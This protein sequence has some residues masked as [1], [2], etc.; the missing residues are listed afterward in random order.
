V[1]IDLL[2]GWDADLVVNGVSV[3]DA[4]LER[5]V[6]LGQV[7]FDP[8]P[9]RAIESLQAGRNCMTATYWALAQPDRTFTRSWCFNAT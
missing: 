1:G 4:Q 3:P 5:I 6:E 7:R 2:T 9:G 8:G